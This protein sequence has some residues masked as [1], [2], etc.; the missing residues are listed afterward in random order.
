MRYAIIAVGLTVGLAGCASDADVASRNLSQAAD[1]FEITRRIVFY[2][3]VNG[4]YI[5]N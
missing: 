4:D 3:G 2:N 5:L 1:Q